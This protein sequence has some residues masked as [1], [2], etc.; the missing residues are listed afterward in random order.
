MGRDDEIA[1]L[2]YFSGKGG[3]SAVILTLFF[4][5]DVV[6]TVCLF[7]MNHREPGR[8]PLLC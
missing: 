8:H 3:E 6:S 4:P 7:I 5:W 1:S 2:L